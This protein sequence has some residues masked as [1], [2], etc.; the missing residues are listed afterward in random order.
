MYVFNK[1]NYG[2]EQNFIKHS[3][4]KAS[5]LKQAEA[6]TKNRSNMSFEETVFYLLDRKYQKNGVFFEGEL[7]PSMTALAGKIDI[8]QSSLYIALV[9]HNKVLDDAVYTI[10]RNK[11]RQIRRGHNPNA[12][13][14]GVSYDSNKQM[15]EAHGISYREACYIA[16]NLQWSHEKVIDEILKVREEES[17]A[18]LVNLPKEEE[19][20]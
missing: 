7:Y 12:V 9:K 20:C 1:V 5:V 15:Y 18:L 6:L 4:I 14:K 10:N 11:Q 3:G 19:T 8:A 16:K 17:K 13:Y 2:T